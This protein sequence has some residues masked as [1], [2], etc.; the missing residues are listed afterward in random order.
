MRTS[1]QSLSSS[2]GGRF[3]VY[4]AEPD[5]PRAPGLLLLQY[6]CGVNDVMRRLAREFAAQGYLVAVPDLFWR[7]E[8][9]VMLANDPARATADDQKR[10]LALN[11]GFEDAPAVDDM[12]V[13]LEFLRRHP[14]CGGKVGTLGYCLGGR[15]AVLLAARSDVDCAVSYYG[16]NIDRYLDEAVAIECPLLMHMAEKD[17]LVGAEARAR[18]VGA[19]SPR[20]QVTIAVH[21]GVNHAFALEGGPNYSATAAASANQASAAFLARHLAPTAPA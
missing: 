7:Q 21:P 17:F 8:P 19:L 15:L 2:D 6:I 16:V 5:A 10:A 20:P 11:D 9:G 13:T 3:D 14:G 4:V 1:T 18:I 12:R